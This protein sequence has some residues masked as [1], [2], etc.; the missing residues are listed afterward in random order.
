[1]A[2][3]DEQIKASVVGGQ[4]YFEVYY[5]WERDTHLRSVSNQAELD[6]VIQLASSTRPPSHVWLMVP[7]MWCESIAQ[8]T[9]M[10]DLA[11]VKE[12]YQGMWQSE[13]LA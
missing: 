4:A 1:M 12:L 7:R 9:T 6:Q 2:L 8:P 11:R 13:E 5:Q 10:E 3:T